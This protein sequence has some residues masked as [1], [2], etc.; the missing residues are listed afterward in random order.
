MN[1][2]RNI[3]KTSYENNRYIRI[4]LLTVTKHYEPEKTKLSWGWSRKTK[5]MENFTNGKNC[6]KQD[7]RGSAVREREGDYEEV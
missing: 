7:M 1:F 3:G 4:N 2:G 5:N 6:R